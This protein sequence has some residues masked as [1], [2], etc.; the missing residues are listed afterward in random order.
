M[1]ELCTALALLSANVIIIYKGHG[2]MDIMRC[3]FVVNFQNVSHPCATLTVW[4]CRVCVWVCVWGGGGLWR[5]AIY[6]TIW[7]PV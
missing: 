7:L 2:L 6:K 5:Y 3:D 1:Y 4:V